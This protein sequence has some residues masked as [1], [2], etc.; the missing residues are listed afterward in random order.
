M[1]LNEIG[2]YREDLGAQDGFD[3]WT[4]IRKKHIYELSMQSYPIKRTKERRTMQ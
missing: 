1:Q 4:K 3:L 2:G